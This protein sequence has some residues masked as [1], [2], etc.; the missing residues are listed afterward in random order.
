MV[1]IS[2]S[3]ITPETLRTVQEQYPQYE[4]VLHSL[5]DI[6]SE[7]VPPEIVIRVND[8]M[9]NLIANLHI[10]AEEVREYSQR[11][12]QSKS[13]REKLVNIIKK[14]AEEN[15]N[16]KNQI[17]DALN[18][19]EQIRNGVALAT[20]G[21]QNTHTSVEDTNQR[22]QVVNTKMQTLQDKFSFSLGMKHL[23][24]KKIKDLREAMDYLSKLSIEPK[25][26]SATNLISNPRYQNVLVGLLLSFPKISLTYLLIS[27]LSED[28]N[29]F[30]KEEREK[31]SKLWHTEYPYSKTQLMTDYYAKRMHPLLLNLFTALNPF[32]SSQDKGIKFFWDRYT[33][34]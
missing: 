29:R 19:N 1:S 28:V 7:G 20:Q 34:L 24:E 16:L 31:H 2:Q 25:N 10:A 17:E 22:G 8:Q 13:E 3:I 18:Q 9:I 4:D 21:V 26:F 11:E 33:R 23:L 32:G 12:E 5:Q 6:P 30:S 27:K 14:L 15:E